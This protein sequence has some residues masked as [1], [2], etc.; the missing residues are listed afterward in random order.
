MLSFFKEK[1]TNMKLLEK[2]YINKNKKTNEVLN[3][4]YISCRKDDQG[5]VKLYDINY[6]DENLVTLDRLKKALGETEFN[7]TDYICVKDFG[8]EFTNWNKGKYFIHITNKNGKRIFSFIDEPLK[9]IEKKNQ[10]KRIFTFT[11]KKIEIQSV[12][13]MLE[14]IDKDKELEQRFLS[15][16]NFFVEKKS[17]LKGLY[18]VIYGTLDNIKHFIIK[19][20]TEAKGDI[21]DIK[22][23]T[24]LDDEYI[25]Y[26]IDN[27][28]IGNPNGDRVNFIKVK[29]KIT[30][31]K[32]QAKV[33]AK[34]KNNGMIFM[35]STYLNNA[36]WKGQT[37]RLNFLRDI[38]DINYYNFEK[39][40]AEHNNYYE[41]EDLNNNKSRSNAKKN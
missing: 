22:E 3:G 24:I 13:K 2:F 40:K 14:I 16:S 19:Y 12:S 5:V 6:F 36:S 17:T 26:I 27:K 38:K 8:S 23:N 9:N 7:K 21:I 29:Q 15:L 10:K 37:K 35:K 30:I 4:S 28:I 32:L 20:D 34:E 18:I 39:Y 1:P 11:K 33:N 41:V 31:D 25:K